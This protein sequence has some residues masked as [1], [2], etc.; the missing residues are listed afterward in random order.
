MKYQDNYYPSL[1]VALLMQY[2][3]SPMCV[4]KM[5]QS[6]IE[7]ITINETDIPV[8]ESGRLLINYLGPAKTFPHYSATDVINNRLAP[9]LLRNKMVIIGAT[10]IGIFD[11]RVTPFSPVFPGVKSMPRLLIIYCIKIFCYNQAG[12]SL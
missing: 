2:W 9:E 11:M 7:G 10:A 12:Q 6:G 4:L 8:D 5:G 1:A 3:D